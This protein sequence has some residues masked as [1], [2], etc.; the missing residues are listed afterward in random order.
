MRL[1]QVPS[2][3]RC[4]AHKLSF[5]FVLFSLIIFSAIIEAKTL[6]ISDLTLSLA[7]IQP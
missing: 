3:L 1:I 2:S 6:L 4:I 5:F 7:P